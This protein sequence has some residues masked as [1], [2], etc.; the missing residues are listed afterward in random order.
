MSVSHPFTQLPSFL[1]KDHKSFSAVLLQEHFSMTKKYHLY[2][3][4]VQFF[5][6][7]VSFFTYV[8]NV[9][10]HVFHLIFPYSC[11]FHFHF[12]KFHNIFQWLLNSRLPLLIHETTEKKCLKHIKCKLIPLKEDIHFAEVQGAPFCVSSLTCAVFHRTKFFIAPLCS[13]VQLLS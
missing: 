12:Y 1:R 13:A 10:M 6:H 3:A 7:S 5:L 9:Y 11:Y 8:I 4:L 2:M